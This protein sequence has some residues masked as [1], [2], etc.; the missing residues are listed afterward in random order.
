MEL[1]KEHSRLLFKQLRI[2]HG[3]NLFWQNTIPIFFNFFPI[4]PA[5]REYQG[6]LKPAS[7]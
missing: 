2:F 6:T 4:D 7:F 3:F 5:F 1:K